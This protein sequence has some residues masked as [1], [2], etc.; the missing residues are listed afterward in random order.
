VIFAGAG[1]CALLAAL[2]VLILLRPG[3]AGG[4]SCT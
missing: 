4:S 3:R 2:L 1:I